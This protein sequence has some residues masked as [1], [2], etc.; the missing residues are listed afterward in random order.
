M[1]TTLEQ[2]STRSAEEQQAINEFM[3]RIESKNPGQTYFL[4]ACYKTI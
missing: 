1:T 3:A 4:Q 2:V